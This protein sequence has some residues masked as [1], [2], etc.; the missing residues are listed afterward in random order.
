MLSA[1]KY[2][3]WQAVSIQVVPEMM[4]RISTHTL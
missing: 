3:T 2:D 1:G 4:H